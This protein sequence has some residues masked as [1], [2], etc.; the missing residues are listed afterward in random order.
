MAS[1]APELLDSREW[2]E[3]PEGIELLLRPAGPAVRALAWLLDTL[4]RLAILWV[5]SMALGLL[6]RFGMGILL[7]VF[8]VLWWLY[9]VLFEVLRDGATP[10]KKM[11]G[12]YVARRD[13]TPVRW[14]E[15]LVRNLLRSVDFLPLVYGVGL[16][17]MLLSRSFQRIGDIA[18]GTLVLYRSSGDRRPAL[19]DARPVAPPIALS[20]DEAQAV[21]G[22]AERVDQLTDERA[23]E[24]A[25]LPAVLTDGAADKRGR[26]IGIAHYLRG[27]R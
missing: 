20:P 21:V 3:T 9:P 27:E 13:G 19:P 8:F 4:L 16:T 22:Y 7:V 17:S 10:G 12:I 18:A 26:L 5:S 24:L 14:G 23:A 15:S 25:A 11:V 1:T 2:V 6:G